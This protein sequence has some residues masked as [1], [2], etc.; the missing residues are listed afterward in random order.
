M[1]TTVS[2]SQFKP[3]VLEYLRLVEQNKQPITITHD[4]KPVVQ[5]VPY[6]KKVSAA[7]AI[8]RGSVISYKDPDKSVG[9]DDWEALK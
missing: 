8:L 6:K 9:L 3:H 2:K 5:V 1:Q 7:R 4:G